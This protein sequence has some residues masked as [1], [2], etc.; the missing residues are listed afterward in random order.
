MR[1]NWFMAVLAL[2]GE[3]SVLKI[4]TDCG[5]TEEQ[6]FVIIAT[7]LRRQSVAQ[8]IL[9]MNR[10]AESFAAERSQPC[11][12]Q[13]V[14]FFSVSLLQHCTVVSGICTRKLHRGV[15]FSEAGLR[16]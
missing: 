12:Q 3:G 5:V 2:L 13:L 11:Q 7:V 4:S 1:L 14:L 16:K 10:I 15:Q 6:I 8:K 9:F